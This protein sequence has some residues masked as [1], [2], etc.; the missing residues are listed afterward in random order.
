MRLVYETNVDFEELDD[1]QGRGD[2][3]PCIREKINVPFHAGNAG[4]E[5][6][7]N[8]KFAKSAS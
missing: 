7:C 3:I 8:F 4:R 1:T 2:E 6:D 5:Y